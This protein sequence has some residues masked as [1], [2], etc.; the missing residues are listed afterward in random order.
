[1]VPQTQYVY[2]EN[3]FE[4]SLAFGGYLF[5]SPA[6]LTPEGRLEIFIP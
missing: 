4:P 6:S 5:L 2:M 1:M 3:C